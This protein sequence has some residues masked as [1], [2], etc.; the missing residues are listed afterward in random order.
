MDDQAEPNPSLTRDS[1]VTLEEVTADNLR[2]IMNLEVTPQQTEFVAPNSVSIAEH[3]FDDNSWMRAVYADGA[4]VGFVLLSEQRDVPRYYLWRYMID[5]RYQA[6]GYGARAMHLVID[7][8]RSL[9]NAEKLFV[10]YVKAPGGP[11]D[12]YARLGFEDTGREHGG[13]FE[14]V[15]AL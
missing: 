12:F 11:R 2:A 13:E 9:P 3:C 1:T 10:S 5:H 15:L 6:M 8:V 4:A 7:Y 14:M